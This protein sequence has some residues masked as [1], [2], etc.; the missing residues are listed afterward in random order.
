MADSETN[1]N[2]AGDTN[3]TEQARVPDSPG[4]R[5]HYDEFYW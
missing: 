5:S 2:G 4:S 3:P 1:N